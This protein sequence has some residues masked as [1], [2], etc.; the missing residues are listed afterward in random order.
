MRTDVSGHVDTTTPVNQHPVQFDVT[1]STTTTTTITFYGSLEFNLIMVENL[2]DLVGQAGRGVVMM[3]GVG[4][5]HTRRLTE[6]MGPAC[7]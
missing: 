5:N 2:I 6:V 4:S 7:I 3:L 1:R